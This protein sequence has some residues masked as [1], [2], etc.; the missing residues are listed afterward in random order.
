MII[1]NQKKLFP[2]DPPE[3]LKKKL[4]RLKLAD[5]KSCG[6]SFPQHEKDWKKNKGNR[7][8]STNPM[9]KVK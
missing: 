4:F 1:T 3:Q 9:P 6:K 5:K 2:S 7:L 8:F